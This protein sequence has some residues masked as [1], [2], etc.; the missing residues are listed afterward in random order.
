MVTHQAG[1]FILAV[2]RPAVYSYLLFTPMPFAVYSDVDVAI[3]ANR[4]QIL[5]IIRSAVRFCFDVVDFRCLRWPAL[6]EAVL[7]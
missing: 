4:N 2:Y 6:S 5:W 1:R 7:A 3:M